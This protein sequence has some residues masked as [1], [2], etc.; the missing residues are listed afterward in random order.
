MEQSIKDIKYSY[1]SFVDGS[2]TKLIEQVIT[3]LDKIYESESLR[4]PKL[5]YQ[6]DNS[7][8]GLIP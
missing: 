2:S 5:I 6:L 4:E 7:E 8:Y 3:G 1:D